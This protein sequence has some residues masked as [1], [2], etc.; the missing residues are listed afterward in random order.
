MT[1]SR[2]EIDKR[3]R[4]RNPEKRKES[5]H[6]SYI[7]F[8]EKNLE[9]KREHYQR[10]KEDAKLDVKPCP[11]CTINYRRLYLKKHMMLRHKLPESELPFDLL[12]KPV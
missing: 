9:R 8:R 4:E 5:S 3:Y 6:N 10:I 7:K 11:I 2:V 1:L 12:C